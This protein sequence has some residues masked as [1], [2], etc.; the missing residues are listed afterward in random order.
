MEKM[1]V[2]SSVR[3]VVL[4][5]G[6][7]VVYLKKTQ[8]PVVSVQ[9]W[10]KTGSV[11]E[12]DGIRGISHFFEHMMFRGSKRVKSEEHA[13][14]INDVG[15]HC[16]AFTAED[17]TA[18]LN[19]VPR[20]YLDLALELEADRMSDLTLTQE[21]L[22]T[23]RNVII[24]EYQGHM[25]NPLA[26]AF[27][28]FRK[29]FFGEYPYSIG[30]I[31]KIEDIRSVTLDDCQNYYR[32]WYTPENAVLVV[33][34][35]FDDDASLLERVQKN[36]GSISASGP[37][38][39]SGRPAAPSPFTA[40]KSVWMKR[41]VDFDVPFLILGYPSPPSSDNDALPIEILQMVMSQGETSRIHRE[42]VR[43]QSLAVMAGG[44]NQS[45]KWAG[46]SLF[47]A[48]FTPDV[49]VRRL[50]K[51]V[52]AQIESMKNGGISEKELEKIKNATLTN[53]IF[54][55]YSAEQIC[56][57]LGHA[58]TVEGDF[59]LWIKRLESL[60]RLDR[61]AL[62]TSAKKYWDD[63]RRHTLYLQPK[64]INPLYFIM[65]LARRVAGRK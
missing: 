49:S 42:I 16:N 8:A 46:M 23:E 33:V 44:I 60:D 56:N 59:R 58:E 34:G 64:K 47:F 24:E 38:R 25:N 30:P 37:E 9:V 20:D 48:M 11:N 50:E 13:R 51:A 1:G 10:Y 6:L 35:D 41:R 31:G 45:L 21:V 52:V 54:E 19:S 29:V 40:G 55:C 32:T 65:G 57:R 53:R 43:R 17:V 12:R 39:S 22:D 15:G 18:Y 2:L 7:K 27:L 62:V 5:N 63:S 3:H 4:D 14:R 36:L 28:E 26:K 61:D